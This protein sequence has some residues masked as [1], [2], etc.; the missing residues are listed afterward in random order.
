MADKE[1]RPDEE[2][3]PEPEPACDARAPWAVVPPRLLEEPG[4]R[5]FTTEIAGRAPRPALEEIGDRGFE[6]PL[7]GGF[8]SARAPPPATIHV[9]IKAATQTPRLLKSFMVCFPD[10]RQE[11]TTPWTQTAKAELFIFCLMLSAHRQPEQLFFGCRGLPT[12]PGRPTSGLLSL[13][14]HHCTSHVI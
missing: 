7:I 14:E 2:T 4:T 11:Q 10:K 12:H 8:A 1:P 6:G 5:L 13:T 9:K 3:R